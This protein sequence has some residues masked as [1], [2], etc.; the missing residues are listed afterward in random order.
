MSKT[1]NKVILLGNVG[2]A[3]EVYA[4]GAG[5]VVCKFSIATSDRY[6]DSDGNWQDR[7]EWT[8]I[9]T[10]GKTAEV[11]RDYATKG[12]KLYVEG[13]LQTSSWD[14]KSSGQ[15]RYKTEVI[16][17]DISLLGGK[18]EEELVPAGGVP[19]DDFNALDSDV[20]F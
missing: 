1:V 7:T 17:S 2:K 11:V 14:D 20:P 6:K 8:N 10:F 4:T 15:K 19:D 3:P 16:A 18:R 5:G 9:V 12:S 13:R